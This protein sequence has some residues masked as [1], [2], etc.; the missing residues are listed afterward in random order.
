MLGSTPRA[1]QENRGRALAQLIERYGGVVVLKGAGSLVGRAD[2]VPWVCDRGNPGMASAGMG[3]VLM[4]HSMAVETPHGNVRRFGSLL[5]DIT[6]TF[7]ANMVRI[8]NDRLGCFLIQRR[9]AKRSISPGQIAK[10][11]GDHQTAEDGSDHATS[12]NQ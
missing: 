7:Q 3:D 8:D 6:V 5:A 2:E 4:S 11:V 12:R 1:V 9:G 10:R